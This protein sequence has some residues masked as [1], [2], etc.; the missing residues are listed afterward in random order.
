M[1]RVTVASRCTT[2]CIKRRSK[3]HDDCRSGLFQESDQCCTHCKKP[4]K[5]I[6]SGFDIVL[7]QARQYITVRQAGQ[8]KVSRNTYSAKWG[9]K[10]AK[11][12]Y[13]SD[14]TAIMMN[15]VQTSIRW[16]TCDLVDGVSGAAH[17]MTDK[18][19]HKRRHDSLFASRR[20][21][22]NQIMQRPGVSRT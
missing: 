20:R 1:C 9:Y 10:H 18:T 3:E 11:T 4:I 2:Y 17:D 7:Q 5:K 12:R 6:A 8:L 13:H 21:V 14:N 15:T 19:Y 16:S 22:G